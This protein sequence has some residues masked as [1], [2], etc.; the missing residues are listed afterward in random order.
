MVKT[1]SKDGE[2]HLWRYTIIASKDAGEMA[3][4]VSKALSEGWQLH[5]SLLVTPFQMVQAMTCEEI[6]DN[7]YAE[8]S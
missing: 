7:T 6:A 8:Q 1:I 4:L 2:T 3:F 5:G